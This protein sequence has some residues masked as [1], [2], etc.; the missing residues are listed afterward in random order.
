MTRFPCP[1]RRLLLQLDNLLS[2]GKLI[3]H[4][5]GGHR[6]CRNGGERRTSSLPRCLRAGLDAS[7]RSW[8]P[9]SVAAANGSDDLNRQLAAADVKMITVQVEAAFA[10]LIGVVK[11]P[12]GDE[13]N[14]S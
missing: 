7:R 1:A 14:Q 5:A 4:R 8:S 13:R 12:S 11:R 10:R 6:S 3:G 9:V 2:K